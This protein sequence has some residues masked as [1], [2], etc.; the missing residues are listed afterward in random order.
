MKKFMFILLLLPVI[1]IGNSFSEARRESKYKTNEIEF[2]GEIQKLLVHQ[3]FENV[4]VRCRL[5]EKKEVIVEYENRRYRY[6]MRAMG[7]VCALASSKCKRIDWLTLIPKNRDI[8]L[9]QV[10]INLQDYDSFIKG[11][12][13]KKIFASRLEIS[14]GLFSNESGTEDISVQT[15]QANDSFRKIGLFINPDINARLGNYDDPYK[16]QLNIIPEVSSFLFKGMKTT[17]ELIIPLENE[18]S[19]EGDDLRPGKVLLNHTF[20]FPNNIFS[21]LNLVSTQK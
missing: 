14:Q 18:L 17:A 20:R 21:S 11:E 12:I 3:G 5:K 6:E 7:V 2:I 19:E 9:V 1:G 8:P 4:V 10:R 13:S 16:L 15:N